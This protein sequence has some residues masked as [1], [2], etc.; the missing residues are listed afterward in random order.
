MSTPAGPTTGT[1]QAVSDEV[2]AELLG[3]G[4]ATVYE[5]SRLDC[6]LPYTLRPAWPGARLAGPAL[7]VRTAAADNLPLHIA[8]E[9]ARPGQ[10]LVVA[11]QGE[12]CGYWGEVLTVAAQQRGIGG[13]VI[14][15]GV[16]DTAALAAR[17][18]PT[19]SSSVAVRGTVKADPGTVGAPIVLGGVT[20]YDGDLVLADSDGVLVLPADR[21]DAV[22]DAAR[23]RQADELRY[24]DRIR[25]GELT[26][27]IY[28]LRDRY[29]AD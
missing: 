27:D 16:R 23:Q 6:F 29:A 24:L 12:P 20:V 19:F 17:D 3:L 1:G 25:R 28:R 26:L 5:A 15:G 14:D 9:A 2:A 21:V 22:L 11:A 18:F 13:L 7:P 10:V 8:V 4:T